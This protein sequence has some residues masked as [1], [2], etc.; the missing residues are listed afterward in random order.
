MSALVEQK[1]MELSKEFR[2]SKNTYLA[3]YLMK[4][5]SRYY[6]FETGW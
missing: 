3:K 2:F 4:S 6:R 5:S 1:F